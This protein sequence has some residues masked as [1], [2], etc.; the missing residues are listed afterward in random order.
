MAALPPGDHRLVLSPEF[1]QQPNMEHI[2]GVS[3]PL[4][5]SRRAEHFRFPCLAERFRPL[6]LHPFLGLPIEAE[7]S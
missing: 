4:A 6:L 7:Q 2:W 5:H 3:L 1:G